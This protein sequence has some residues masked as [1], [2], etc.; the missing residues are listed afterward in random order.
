MFVPPAGQQTGGG[1]WVVLT[2]LGLVCLTVALMVLLRRLE[3]RKR[4]RLDDYRWH[5]YGKIW[6]TTRG[7]MDFLL[8]ENEP[9]AEEVCYDMRRLH[10]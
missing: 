5:E 2:V 10:D 6:R 4:R 3:A 9:A 7:R 8:W 1:T